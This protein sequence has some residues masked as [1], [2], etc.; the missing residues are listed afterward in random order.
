MK[1]L[2]IREG[3]RMMPKY[4]RIQFKASERKAYDDRDVFKR[5]MLGKITAEQG[6]R[7]ISLNNMTPVTV[8]QFLANADWLGYAGGRR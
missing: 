1:K 3:T 2:P 6:A 8:E 7:L 4:F 5:W